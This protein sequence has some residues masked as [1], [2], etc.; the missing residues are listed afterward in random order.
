[1]ETIRKNNSLIKITLIVL[2]ILFLILFLADFIYIKQFN[3]KE[4]EFVTTDEDYSVNLSIGGRADSTSEWKKRQFNMYGRLVD[5][6]AQTIDVI[7]SNDTNYEIK[8]W[9]FRIDFNEECFFN[10]AWCGTVEIHQNVLNDEK[11][12]T[13]D[14]RNYNLD[15]IELDYLYDGDLLIHLNEGDYII[16]YPSIKD[17]EL[18][19]EKQSQMTTG[20]IVYYLEFPDM[21]NNKISYTFNRKITDDYVIYVLGILFLGWALLV[22]IYAVYY[23]TYRA[24]VKEIEIKKSGIASMSDMYA[25]IYIIDIKK[26]ELIP[27]VA[28]E[29]SEKLRPKNLNAF[30]QLRNMFEYDCQDVYLDVA[31]E[32]CNIDTLRERLENKNTVVFEYKS[33]YYGWCRTR[34]FAMDKEKNLPLEKVVFT[35]QVINDEKEELEAISQRVDI[36]E[37]ENNVKSTFLANMSHEIRTPINTVIGFDTMILRE[38]KDPLIKSYAKKINSAANM[39]LSI[40]NGILDISK[41]E[42]EKMEIIPEEYSFKQMIS[43]VVTMIKGRTEFEKLQF[44]C[45]VS[46]DI[47]ALLF[48]DAVRLKQVIINLL[49]NAAKYTDKGSV[50][51]TIYG[52]KHDDKEHL[53]ISVKDTGIGIREED[54]KKLSERFSRFDE[55]RNHTVEGT[56]LGLNLVTG[57]LRLMDSELNVISTYG[58]GSEFYFEIEQKIISEETIGVT[59]FEMEI[60]DDEYRALFLAPDARILV[61]D[62]NEMNLSVFINL[63]KETKLQIETANSGVMAI[64]KCSTSKYDLIFM[65]HMMPGMDGVECFNQIRNDEDALNY[66]T[67][68]IILTANALK[69]AKEE[70]EALGFDDFLAKPIVA[71]ELEHMI[72]NYLDPSK[73]RESSGS[74]GK[75]EKKIEIP[76]F[77]G[78]DISYG[79]SHTGDMSNYLVLLKQVN[80]IGVVD[81]NELKE[82]LKVLTA[83]NDDYEALHD[84]RIKIHSMKSTVNILGALRLYGLAA[85]IEEMS[86][87]EKVK[88]V[89]QLTPFF[90]DGFENLLSEIKDYFGD[91]IIIKKSVDTEQINEFLHSLETSIKVY[92]IKNAD[93]LIE[94]LKSFEWND[95]DAE[96]I[97][98]LEISVANLNA[99]EVVLICNKLKK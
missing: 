34:F 66:S 53:L 79:V 75:D 77:S 2:P 29:E 80:N 36:A 92:D 19:V 71:D 24:A 65:D 85:T 69:G 93:S 22:I 11:V 26:N 37:H 82:Y 13:L 32:F 49:T 60:E 61:V 14:L 51:L 57:I 64:E 17:N 12:Q 7:F 4:H 9:K 68:V 33:K 96:L 39:L 8:N 21:S 72:L 88:E 97:Q 76:S 40:I 63:L 56:G 1:M 23:F 10:N 47:P 67:K 54:L 55:K 42:A 48:G 87:K 43:E 31:L 38:S 58:E 46:P 99:E 44:I 35:I 86:S 81:L 74:K 59:D 50:K 5:L 27:V 41:L 52:K 28:D 20:F 91:E 78:V 98:K 6:N 45:E 89:L 84:F 95:E 18:P 94:K 15:E 70:Y 90:I 62:D 25:I 16:Y 30:D 73:I 83:N 3:K